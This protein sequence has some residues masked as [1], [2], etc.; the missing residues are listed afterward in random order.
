M[1]NTAS[2]KVICV[3]IGCITFLVGWALAFGHDGVILSA[4]LALIAALGG[5]RLGFTKG[6]GDAATADLE[7][8]SRPP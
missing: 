1:I 7:A 6:G 3:A 8:V 2:D 5:Y 4:A